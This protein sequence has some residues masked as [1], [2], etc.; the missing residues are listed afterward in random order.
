MGVV[1]LQGRGKGISAGIGRPHGGVYRRDSR[2]LRPHTRRSGRHVHGLG[3]RPI[4]FWSPGVVEGAALCRAC[5]TGSGRCGSSLASGSRS[6]FSRK[7]SLPLQGIGWFIFR[8]TRVARGSHHDPRLQAAPRR[9]NRG[10]ARK[11][12]TTFPTSAGWREDVGRA[13]AGPLQCRAQVYKATAWHVN[14]LT[15]SSSSRRLTLT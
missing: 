1:R 9:G 5:Q 4:D 12:S 7:K 8:C 11:L 6:G 2:A 13:E 10:V 14:L 3:A 15:I